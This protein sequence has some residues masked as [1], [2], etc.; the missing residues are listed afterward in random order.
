MNLICEPPY[1]IGFIGSFNF[2]GQVIGAI[3]L[4]RLGDRYGRKPV[5]LLTSLVYIIMTFYTL[6]ALNLSHIYISFFIL[7]LVSLTRTSCNYMMKIEL[8]TKDD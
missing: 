5:Y 8:V 6:F 4:I 1:M 3:F 2:L 7:G